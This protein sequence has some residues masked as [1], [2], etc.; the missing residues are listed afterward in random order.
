[1][2]PN[3]LKTEVKR[4]LTNTHNKNIKSEDDRYDTIDFD[5]SK[6]RKTT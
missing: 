2:I 5:R 3:R 6:S 4:L 1:M